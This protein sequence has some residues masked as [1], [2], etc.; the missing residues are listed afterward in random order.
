M[1]IIS[2]VKIKEKQTSRQ[3]D[4]Q[5]KYKQTKR[6]DQTSTDKQTGGAVDKIVDNCKVAYIYMFTNRYS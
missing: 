6:H 4:N 1:Q 3:P 2:V 5:T